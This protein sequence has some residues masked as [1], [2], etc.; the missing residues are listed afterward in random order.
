MLRLL[1][2]LLNNEIEL[3]YVKFIINSKIVNIKALILKA[4]QNFRRKYFMTSEKFFGKTIEIFKLTR[5]E[6]NYL[7]CN[8]T[9]LNSIQ[10]QAL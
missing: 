9:R 4:V 6:L 7:K 3:I 2:V 8:T 1:I 5:K 10:Y